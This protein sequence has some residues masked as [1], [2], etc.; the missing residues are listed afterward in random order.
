MLDTDINGNSRL[1]HPSFIKSVDLVSLISGLMENEKYSE[2]SSDTH[3]S[4]THML[5]LLSNIL[6]ILKIESGKSE[7]DLGL[8]DFGPLCAFCTLVINHFSKT[9]GHSLSLNI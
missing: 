1:R 9:Q 7:I 6:D 4:A 5:K 3:S 2:Y 8:V